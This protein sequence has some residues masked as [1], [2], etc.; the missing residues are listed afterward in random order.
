[1]FSIILYFILRFVKL[2]YIV[3]TELHKFSII[4]CKI[5]AIFRNKNTLYKHNTRKR[6]FREEK[7]ESIT[8][9]KRRKNYDKP[10]S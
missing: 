8:R 6:F 3:N 4:N 5:W 7:K 2:K 10:T 1:M 9:E